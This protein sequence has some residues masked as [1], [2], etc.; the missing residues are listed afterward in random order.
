MFQVDV[1]LKK[2]AKAAALTRKSRPGRL[3]DTS[4]SSRAISTMLY[5]RPG[6]VGALSP[7]FVRGRGRYPVRVRES[8]TPSPP[9]GARPP[10]S[11]IRSGIGDA[12]P[13]ESPAP[14]PTGGRWGPRM[15][16]LEIR[17]ESPGLMLTISTSSI[18]KDPH[19]VRLTQNPPSTVTWHRDWPV[20]RRPSL[21]RS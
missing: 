5:F 18:L 9:H 21:T 15:Q 20:A 14:N 1:N 11:S 10:A 6:T 19:S 2:D 3:A 13:S 12:P 8:P 17:L 4:F 7:R 16:E